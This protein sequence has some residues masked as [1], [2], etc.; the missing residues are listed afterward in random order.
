MVLIWSTRAFV[1]LFFNDFAFMPAIHNCVINP[2][3]VVCLAH[4]AVL[5]LAFPR[6]TAIY[7]N[8]FVTLA[9]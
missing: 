4:L 2:V 3:C 7:L 5:R 9:H 6:D 1:N 8:F